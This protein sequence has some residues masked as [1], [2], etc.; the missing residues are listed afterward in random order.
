MPT[1]TSKCIAPS[2]LCTCKIILHKLVLQVNNFMD[3]NPLLHWTHHNLYCSHADKIGHIINMEGSSQLEH[4]MYS[5]SQEPFPLQLRLSRVC[6]CSIMQRHQRL[7]NHQSCI[8][9]AYRKAIKPQTSMLCRPVLSE[10]LVLTYTKDKRY[11]WTNTVCKF[12]HGSK[13]KEP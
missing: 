4:F 10:P 5:L 1:V 12:T 3:S 9:P 11:K 8:S 2:K 13:Q 6:A 7:E